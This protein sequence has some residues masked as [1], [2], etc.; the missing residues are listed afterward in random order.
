M[1]TSQ[2]SKGTALQGGKYH[3]ESVLGQGG[4]GIT[5]LATQSQLNRKVAIKEFFMH[6]FCSREGNATS[7]T[8]GTVS[9]RKTVECFLNKF[10]KEARTIAA[11]AHPNIIQIHDIFEE[12]NTVYYVMDYIEGE[13][14]SQIVK[15][16]GALPESEAVGYICSVA[17]ALKYIHARN[18]NHLDVKPGNIMVRHTD[19]HVFLLDFGLSKQYD[20]EGNQTSS[21]PVGISHGY[22]PIEQYQPGGVKEFSPQTD[23]YALG[24]TLYYVVTGI[25]PPSATEMFD[26]ELAYPETLS[27]SVCNA[28]SQAMKIQK[29]ERPKDADAFLVMLAGWISKDAMIKQEEEIPASKVEEQEAKQKRH[30]NNHW[31]AKMLRLLM[32]LSLTIGGI[33]VLFFLPTT[34]SQVSEVELL[35]EDPH[36]IRYVV[37]M[38]RYKSQIDS[39]VFI[40]YNQTTGEARICNF[41]KCRVIYEE[42][43]ALA[44]EFKETFEHPNFQ[45]LQDEEFKRYAADVANM[46]IVDEARKASYRNALRIKND[47]EA[48]AYLDSLLNC[49]PLSEMTLTPTKKMMSD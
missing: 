17:E 13:S 22:A 41:E 16:Q 40:I 32:V 43:T 31:D 19:N 23:I 14:L 34:E 28:I 44:D 38:D 42:A 35:A 11:L 29:K 48:K 36:G 5:Y 39:L 27:T 49:F 25:V 8:L 12:N 9:N 33:Y 47:E 10:M 6:D 45:Q 26:T 15:R 30:S 21:T 24:A 46:D 18:I 4:F 20:A 7:V 1:D 37:Q 3:I 2:L